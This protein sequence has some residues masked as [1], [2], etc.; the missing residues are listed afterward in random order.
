[1]SDQQVA[2]VANYVRSHFGN[3]YGDTVT[4]AAVKAARPPG[5]PDP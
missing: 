4:V 5:P 3:A 1:M 2:D